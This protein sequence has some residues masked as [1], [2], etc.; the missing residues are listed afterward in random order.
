MLD[1]PFGLRKTL[2]A[3]K[4]AYK[5]AK[6]AGI[7]CGIK[8]CG[9]GNGMPDI[10]KSALYVEDADT[11]HI[12]TGFT[13]MGQGLFTTLHPV[14]RRGDR[15]AGRH[16][17]ESFD[18]HEIHARLRSNDGQPRH[19]ARRELD[20]RGRQSNSKPNS[21]AGKTL[22]DLVGQTFIGE[23]SCTYTSKLG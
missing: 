2:E 19:G 11:I 9:I 4:D 10:G 7:A 23:W 3:V 18:R 6:Y 15:S 16:F 22:A 1:K 20:R 13:E 5:T 17:Q 21:T 14:R 8:N 12:H